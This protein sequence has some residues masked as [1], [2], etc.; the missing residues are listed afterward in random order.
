MNI[1][2]YTVIYL[3]I[4]DSIHFI[5]WFGCFFFLSF[6]NYKQQMDKSSVEINEIDHLSFGMG[7]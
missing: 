6:I 2:F 5:N 3:H 4:F 1:T 7:M